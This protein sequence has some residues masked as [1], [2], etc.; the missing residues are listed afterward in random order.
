MMLIEATSDDSCSSF[1]PGVSILRQICQV[2]R[3]KTT[4]QELIASYTTRRIPFN[5]LRQSSTS[6]S[7]ALCWYVNI[8]FTFSSIRRQI[9][10][11]QW[12]HVWTGFQV[13]HSSFTPLCCQQCLWHWPSLFLWHYINFVANNNNYYNI[14][15]FL[16]LRTPGNIFLSHWLLPGQNFPWCRS[17]GVRKL[18]N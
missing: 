2:W 15:L 18:K 10:L 9:S 3:Q 16:Q 13:F 17:K 14:W 11:R 5:H 4:S 12:T 1:H 6:S 8:V 7:S